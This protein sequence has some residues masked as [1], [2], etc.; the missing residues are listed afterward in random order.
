MARLYEITKA[1]VINF[2]QKRNCNFQILEHR[3]YMVSFTRCTHLLREP[4]YYG[5]L[6]PSLFLSSPYLSSFRQFR[7]KVIWDY[8]LMKI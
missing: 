6:N 2:A 8:I 4:R 5:G 3:V 1:S 7:S